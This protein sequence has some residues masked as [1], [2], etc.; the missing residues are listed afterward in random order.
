MMC[1]YYFT[2]LREFYTRISVYTQFAT[3]LNA[4]SSWGGC[5]L[6]VPISHAPVVR[7]QAVPFSTSKARVPLVYKKHSRTII[8]VIVT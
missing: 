2:G 7:R 1:D 4:F 8:T 6:Y 5:G 3:D